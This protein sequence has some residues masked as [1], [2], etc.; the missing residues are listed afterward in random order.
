[1]STLG[2][3]I[4][5]RVMGRGGAAARGQS[6]P[7]GYAYRVQ[8]ATTKQSYTKLDATDDKLFY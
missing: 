4:T 8:R 6:A 5:P 1:M 2:D 3:L 7:T